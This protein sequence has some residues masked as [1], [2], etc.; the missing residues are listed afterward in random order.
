MPFSLTELICSH[1][2]QPI[3]FADPS[4]PFQFYLDQIGSPSL[5]IPKYHYETSPVVFSTYKPSTMLFSPASRSMSTL[6]SNSV[7]TNKTKLTTEEEKLQ[8]TT[9]PVVTKSKSKPRWRVDLKK[10]RCDLCSQCFSRSNTLVTHRVSQ[11][12]STIPH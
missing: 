9:S 3:L 11:I 12:S 6:S 4:I 8:T 7:I 2:R 5:Y 1:R 10:Y